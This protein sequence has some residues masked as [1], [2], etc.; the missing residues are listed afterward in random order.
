[1]STAAQSIRH[2]LPDRHGGEPLRLTNGEAFALRALCIAAGDPAIA[3]RLEC[4]AADVLREW[5]GHVCAEEMQE[6]P[7]VW[8]R[9]LAFLES[10]GWR[11]PA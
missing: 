2:D 11:L 6:L 5:P 7:G 3:R 4:I 10:S 1:M 9:L 8:P